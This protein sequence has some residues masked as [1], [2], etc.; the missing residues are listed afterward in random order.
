MKFVKPRVII[1]K[2]I[3]FDNCRYNSNIIRSD[4]VKILMNF[5][6]FIPICPEVEIGLGIPRD[7]IRLI[8]KNDELKLLNTS[9]N[10]DLTNEMN[11]F[12]NDF[13]NSI[14][15]PD[16]FILK[17]KSPS[18]GILSTPYLANN[19][20]SA[21]KVGKGPGLFGKAVKKKFSQLPVE[22]ESR[23]NNFHIRE[24]FL[25]NL[26]TIAR[27]RKIKESQ[28]IRKL[29]KFQTENKFLLMAYNQ[30]EMRKLGQLV[31]NQEKLSF[32]EIISDYEHCLFKILASPPRNTSNVNVLKHILGYFSKKL[33]TEEKAF[34]L[35]ELEKYRTGWIP[36][37]LLIRLLKIWIVRF[38]QEYLKSQ[39]FL[40]PFPEE[41]IMF[42]L[43]DIWKDKSY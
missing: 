27:F 17:S 8:K 21:P 14:D 18:C 29:V 16:G 31:A 30:E 20:K 28:K 15:Q 26:Y 40:E 37:L 24:Y 35:D 43:K 39:T 11:H 25:T 5:V 3:E 1:S 36:L 13:L 7:P 12:S 33:N 9:T 6:D 34:F 19:Q 42:D 41:L 23:L 32:N 10:L 2:C 38:D 22:S 4:L